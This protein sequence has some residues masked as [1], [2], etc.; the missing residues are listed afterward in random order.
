MICIW[1]RCIKAISCC[2]RRNVGLWVEMV[3]GSRKGTQ[4]RSD[5]NL[6]YEAW[7]GLFLARSWWQGHLSL[8][9]KVAQS[10]LTP[11]DPMDYTV[12]GILQARILEWVAMPSSRRSS[13]PSDRTQV[14]G[15][16]GGFFTNWGIR[17]AHLNLR[18]KKQHFWLRRDF[19]ML[20]N[21]ICPGGCQLE[22]RENDGKRWH[23]RT[24]RG[25]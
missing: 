3:W 13:Q 2:Y 9:V 17:E 7:K 23:V 12:H 1:E 22:W 15:I 4:E 20:K 11:C 21:W 10:C 24:W 19:D 14:Y 5:F 6:K 16:A 18:D 8:K 25:R